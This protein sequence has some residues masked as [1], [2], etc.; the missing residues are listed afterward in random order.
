VFY[1]LERQ[2]A[3][4][5]FQ[6][7][8]RVLTF[9]RSFNNTAGASSTLVAALATIQS[10]IAVA[11]DR[12]RVAAQAWE[13]ERAVSVSLTVQMAEAQRLLLGRV[14]HPPPPPGADPSEPPHF[15]ARRRQHRRSS[16]LGDRSSQ[17][18]VPGL[19]CAGFSVTPSPDRNLLGTLP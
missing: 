8:I 9:K 16:R 1:S 17:H 13:S 12:E 2:N 7:L 10:A 4:T 18:L 5:W 11:R 14:D 15:R 3:K 6:P 19:R